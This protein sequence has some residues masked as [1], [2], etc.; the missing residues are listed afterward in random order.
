MALHMSCACVTC[1]H[2]QGQSD[3]HRATKIKRKPSIKAR[4]TCMGRQAGHARFA[5]RSMAVIALCEIAVLLY[6]LQAFCFFI[7][8]E[9][10]P[11]FLSSFCIAFGA[12][13]DDV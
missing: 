11:G 8:S 5:E 9:C 1:I 2:L 7:Y 4:K 12:A 13:S 3:I 6:Q 10:F